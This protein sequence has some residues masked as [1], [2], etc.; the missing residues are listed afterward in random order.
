MPL[1]DGSEM[2]FSFID[3]PGHKLFVRNM[4]AG[5]GCI[6]A[7]MLIISAEEGIKPQTQEH[8]AICGL[9][10]ITRGLVVVTK[11]D[12]VNAD[13]LDRVLLEAK[14]L[15]E[16][17]PL[18]SA[19]ILAASARTGYRPEDVRRELLRVGQEIP[20]H[21]PDRLTRL[22]LDRAFVMKGFGT[23]VT[24]TLLS[25]ALKTSGNRFRWQP[26]GLPSS[27]SWD[28]DAWALNGDSARGIARCAEPR[29][30]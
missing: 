6:D 26:G 19:R 5:T 23:V 28:P 12:A 22:P 9:L 29:R 17:S 10:G 3:V 14:K 21:D 27:H 20:L 30:H 2:L 16:S 11:R 1:D 7:V 25:G 24:G 4:L 15:L 8:L 13:Q 18:S